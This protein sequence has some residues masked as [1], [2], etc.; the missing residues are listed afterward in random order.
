MNRSIPVLTFI[1]EKVAFVVRSVLT[2]LLFPT[3]PLKM[4]NP[5]EVKIVAIK[6]IPIN[7]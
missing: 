2:T 7:M 6:R 1:P 5:Q 4:S 3:T